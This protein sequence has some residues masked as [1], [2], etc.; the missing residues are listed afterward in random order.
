[1]PFSINI[2]YKKD[3]E[4]SKINPLIQYQYY[5][6]FIVSHT[7]FNTI[8]QLNYQSILVLHIYNQFVRFYQK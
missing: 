8:I 3:H 4:A 1:M 6:S 2:I 7:S 5:N